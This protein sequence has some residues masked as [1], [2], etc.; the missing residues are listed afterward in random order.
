MRA[1]YGDGTVSG[2]PRILARRYARALFEAALSQGPAAEAPLRAEIEGFVRVL[3]AVPELRSAL[4]NPAI[5]PEQKSRVLAAIAARARVSPL[6]VRLLALLAR[7][8]RLDLLGELALAY[9]EEHNRAAG[10]V[11]ATAI[12]AVALEGPQLRALANAL[13][14]AVGSQVELKSEVD[15]GL[16]GGLLVRV[17][18]RTYD[19]SVRAR[20]GAL[21]R[22]LAIG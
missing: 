12:S 10:V 6:F 3:D 13:G 22:R 20:L 5:T 14:V 16:L 18:G 8:E 17:G 15:P 9:A 21:R 7:H 2:Q 1:V 4:H 11:T 19:G